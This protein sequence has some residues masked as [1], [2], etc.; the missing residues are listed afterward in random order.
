[1]NPK[2]EENILSSSTRVKKLESALK[3]TI[4]A[5]RLSRA[6]GQFPNS[7]IMKEGIMEEA[8]TISKDLENKMTR[9]KIEWI[10]CISLFLALKEDKNIT[11]QFTVHCGLKP[12]NFLQ[13]AK[14][15]KEALLAPSCGQTAP[16]GHEDY[17][18][19]RRWC[20]PW[21]PL[22]WTE[23]LWDKVPDGGHLDSRD[24]SHCCT[25]EDHSKTQS[26]C[27]P[28][29]LGPS[30]T[31]ACRRCDGER[32]DWEKKE[33]G[34]GCISSQTHWLQVLICI[35]YGC[36]ISITFYVDKNHNSRFPISSKE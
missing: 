13:L 6:R 3:T 28:W 15:C 32:Q 10:A 8:I 30:I 18:K 26:R 9:M 4:D 25:C 5:F 7:D 11:N 23:C 16:G 29:G 2:P 34:S 14:R 22:I 33:C 17:S 19:K 1:M 35:S 21:G 31:S 27:A 24:T 20:P 12:L 36:C